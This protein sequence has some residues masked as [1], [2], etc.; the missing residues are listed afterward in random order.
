[1]D[2]RVRVGVMEEVAVLGEAGAPSFLDHE[3]ED[4]DELGRL[5]ERLCY[6]DD[7]KLYRWERIVHPVEGRLLRFILELFDGGA[8]FEWR[9]LPDGPRIWA[10][11][12]DAE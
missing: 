6:D 8:S 3:R 5:V 11:R 2:E 10:S 12:F 9:Y 7:G 4:F 1:M